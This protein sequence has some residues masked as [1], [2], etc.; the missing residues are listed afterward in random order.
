MIGNIKTFFLQSYLSFLKVY[1]WSLKRKVLDRSLTFILW[2]SMGFW[3]YNSGQTS[4][5]NKCADQLMPYVDDYRE[6]LDDHNKLI[7][8]H[9]SYLIKTATELKLIL[10]LVEEMENEE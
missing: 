10:Q 9:N 5:Y 2:L 3:I 6:L 4:G 8:H 1:L 7:K